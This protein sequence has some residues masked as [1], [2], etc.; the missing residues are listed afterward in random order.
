MNICSYNFQHSTCSHQFVVWEYKGSSPNW[1]LK[2]CL[3]GGCTGTL[4]QLRLHL[5]LMWDILALFK[6]GCRCRLNLVMYMLLLLS[7]AAISLILITIY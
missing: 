4:F 1:N 7:I 5:M 2:S 3:W 6:S